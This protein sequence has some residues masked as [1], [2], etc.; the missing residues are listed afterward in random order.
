MLKEKCREAKLPLS[1]KKEELVARV[2][3]YLHD[4]ALEQLNM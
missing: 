1:G 4:K 2:S 3:K